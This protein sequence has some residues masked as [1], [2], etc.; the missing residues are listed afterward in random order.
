MAAS[1]QRVDANG[2]EVFS[3]I[4]SHLFADLIEKG[5]VA[6]V[7]DTYDESESV[8]VRNR[9]LKQS[10][11][12][13]TQSILSNGTEGLDMASAVRQWRCLRHLTAVGVAVVTSNG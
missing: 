12:L 13:V 6:H 1:L 8:N 11:R 2:S 5:T 3:I 9:A 4:L 7:E 10:A